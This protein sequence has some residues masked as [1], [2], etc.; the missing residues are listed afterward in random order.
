MG[1]SHYRG[2]ASAVT[3]A[4][5]APHPLCR[6]S[7]SPFADSTPRNIG[8]LRGRHLYLEVAP[9]ALT[10]QLVDSRG[11]SQAAHQ[12]WCV[13]VCRCFFLCWGAMAPQNKLK[14]ELCFIIRDKSAAMAIKLVKV[15]PIAHLASCYNPTLHWV[16][17]YQQAALYYVARQGH[18]KACAYFGAASHRREPS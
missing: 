7:K 4:S 6:P 2:S 12:F 16:D 5:R 10:R 14:N 15:A 17:E 1:S 13:C 8:P 11:G 18:T 3:N 9:H